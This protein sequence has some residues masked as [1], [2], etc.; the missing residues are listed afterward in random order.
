MSRRSFPEWRP[1]QS[2]HALPVGYLSSRR[3]EALRHLESDA[4]PK[5]AL[6]D[7]FVSYFVQVKTE[8]WRQYQSTLSE[9]EIQCN[10]ITF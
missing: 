1:N 9:L 4:V 2:Q 6:G 8:E 10:L 5:Q 3:R 7:D